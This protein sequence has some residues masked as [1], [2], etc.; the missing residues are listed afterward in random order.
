MS[1]RIAAQALTRAH[2]KVEVASD[3]ETAVDLF[4]SLQS[5]LRVILMDINLPGISGIDATERIRQWERDHDI[6]SPVMIFGLTGNVDGENLRAYE[7]V[8]P[9]CCVLC[10]T[11][12]FFLIQAGMNGCIMKGNLLAESVR[13]AVEALT[14]SPD[15]FIDLTTS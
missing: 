8:G 6:K 3:G 10:Y 2:Y 7:A 12:R 9:F 5:S 1:Q 4:I 14:R 13:K 11:H 15:T